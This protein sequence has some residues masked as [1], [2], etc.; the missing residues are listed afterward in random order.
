LQRGIADL[1]HRVLGGFAA[2]RGDVGKLLI[3][4]G[5]NFHRANQRPADRRAKPGD[6][7]TD[8]LQRVGF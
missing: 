6:I 5:G 1:L 7:G 8:R 4:V 3:E 2:D